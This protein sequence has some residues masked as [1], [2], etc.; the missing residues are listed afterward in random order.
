MPMDMD[1]RQLEYAVKL[2]EQLSRN[3]DRLAQ[4]GGR[5]AQ[6][7]GTSIEDIVDHVD[8]LRDEI[9]DASD[10]SE[11]RVVDTFKEIE[12]RYEDFH[13]YSTTRIHLFGSEWEKTLD[14][15]EKKWQEY[16]REVQ[17]QMTRAAGSA[18]GAAG[19][20]TG[21]TSVAG[22]LASFKSQLFA[23]MPF[24]I[25]GLLGLA[26]WG[27]K[28][29]EE[30]NAAAR[31]SV[32]Q[33]QAAGGVAR[34]YVPELTAQIR[35]MYEAWGSMGEEIEA[36]L[37]GF[38]QFSIAEEAF[39]STGLAAEGFMQNITGIAT[40]V[41]L[42][43]AAAP[44][45]TAKLIG[46]TMLNASVSVEEAAN[47]VFSL[48]G[49]LR[50]AKLNYGQFGAGIVQATS[51][52]RIQNQSLEDTSKLFL[53]LQKRFEL[54][55]MS[56]QRAAQMAMTGVQAATQAIGGLPQG[57]QGVIAQR[58]AAQGA[59]G[60]SGMKDPF[61][62]MVK[63]QEGLS[64]GGPFASMVFGEL[65]KVAE[66]AAGTSGTG[67]ERRMRQIGTLQALG[68]PS[69]EA[70]RAIIDGKD[71]TEKLLTPAE[72]NAKFTKDLFKSFEEYSKRQSTFERDMRILQDTLAQ[73]GGDILTVLSSELSVLVEHFKMFPT[74]MKDMLHTKTFGV[75]GTK[76]GDQDIQRL[77]A[78]GEFSNRV[79]DIQLDAFIAMGPKFSKIVE[80]MKES[81]GR[82]TTGRVSS[83]AGAFEAYE[84][85]AQELPP[86]A[87]WP[88]DKTR[89]MIK[90]LNEPVAATSDDAA[91]ELEA[92]ASAQ[93]IAAQRTKNAASIMRMTKAWKKAQR[94]RRATE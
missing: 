90:K 77:M 32:F 8:E 37:A 44:G 20:A 18:M 72:E 89:E 46:E 70:A 56:R 26:L 87:F 47:Q 42:M 81:T 66:K 28:R 31:R 34:D 76:M 3:V 24:G 17:R 54:Q 94:E 53:S 23:G 2:V 10:E 48:A 92:A 7:L 91:D 52:L 33:L 78:L 63:M 41:D 45:T 55:G 12:R 79:T 59:E 40:A 5:V 83:L 82:A 35:T 1:P 49:A 22:G 85:R 19:S 6:Q 67:E 25:G 36:T 80:T 50:E 4:L 65:R 9:D 64:K 88:P 16:G 29:E 62:L 86:E 38:A 27:L 93:E 73:I 71:A 11:R 61:A 14:R 30:F 60:F 15:L 84:R 58:L 75:M 74:V 13:R 21:L 43:N 69:F 51:A 39:T 57:L 68:I